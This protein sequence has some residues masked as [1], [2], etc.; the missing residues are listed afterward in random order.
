M[1]LVLQPYWSPGVR[2]PGPEAKGAVIGFGG[3][4]TRA[5]LYRAILE[6][7]P[8][9]PPRAPAGCERT[10]GRAHTELRVAGAARRA[11]LPCRSPPT[12]RLPA[13]RPHVYERPGL[14]AAIRRRGRARPACR[15]PHR[16]ERD[17]HLGRDL[18][19]ER[20]P[21]PLYDDLYHQV[22]RRMYRRLRPLYH[23]IR[24]IHRYPS[25]PE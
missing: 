1:G 5:H 3:V 14:G 18:R 10:I 16:G 2:Y 4:H 25:L 8:T 17:G 13:S 21:P 7:W 6:G 15:F 19:A 22:Y 20:A 9:R 24:V 11:A 12:F 23:R